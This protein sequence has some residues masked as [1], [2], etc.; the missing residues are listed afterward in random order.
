MEKDGGLAFAAAA[1][2]SDDGSAGMTLRQW[3]KGQAPPA[4]AASSNASGAKERMCQ[5]AKW[6]GEWA[7]AMLA[8]DESHEARL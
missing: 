6:A 4:P 3:Y 5:R 7:D 8:E 2:D 1:S